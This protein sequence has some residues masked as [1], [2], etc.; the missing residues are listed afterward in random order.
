MGGAE[1]IG[2][3]RT[4][5]GEPVPC[6]FVGEVILSKSNKYKVGDRVASFS[7]LF[8]YCAFSTE[9]L[10]PTKLPSFAST[11]KALVME[12]CLTALIVINHHPCGR[13]HANSGGGA[14]L[15]ACMSFLKRQPQKTVLV[16]SAAGGVGAMAG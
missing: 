5:I 11:E 9:K 13:V 16:T 6:E 7:P 15:A 4:K 1:A 8:E 3:S 12:A 14:G 10:P 2:L